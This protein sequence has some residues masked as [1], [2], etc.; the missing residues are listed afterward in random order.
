M[1]LT[2][3]VLKLLD[4]EWQI[5]PKDLKMKCRSRIDENSVIEYE[6][7]QLMQMDNTS[8]SQSLLNSNKDEMIK[9]YLRKNFI[10]FYINIYK[11]NAPAAVITNSGKPGG[12]GASPA[13]GGGGSGANPHAGGTTPSASA[14]SSANMEDMSGGVT[15]YMLDVHLFKGTVFVFMDFVRKFMHVLTASCSMCI[16]NSACNSS[17]HS[18]TFEVMSSQGQPHLHHDYKLKMLF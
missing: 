14:M 6:Q 8:E 16:S 10:K 15:K 17:A 12:P 5:I 3:E 13:V 2:C 18:S 9:E 4:I 1:S 7:Q 11:D